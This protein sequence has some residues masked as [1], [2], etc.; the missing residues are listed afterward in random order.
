MANALGTR[1][2]D[3][4]MRIVHSLPR[5]GRELPDRTIA[6]SWIRCANDY[7]LDPARPDAPTIIEARALQDRREQLADLM[8]I[9]AAE[10]D[11]L[12]DQISGSGYALLLTDSD[13]IILY[14]KVDPTLKDMFRGAGL[15]PGADWSERS[16]GTNGMGTCIAERKPVTVHRNDHFY[17]H[18]IGLTCFGV[19]IRGPVD[20]VIAVL[21]ASCIGSHDTRATQMHTMALVRL[22][23]HIIEKCLFLRH[24]E[25]NAVLRFHSR[26]DLVN[27]FHDG[28]LA[29]AE[30]G[31]VIGA[32]HTAAE[33]LEAKDRYE[34][35]G[36]PISEIFDVDGAR[37]ASLE[38]LRSAS[39]SPL[40]DPRRGQGY[41]ANLYAGAKYGQSMSTSIGHGAKSSTR[42][43]PE[44]VKLPAKPS[45]PVLT[46]EDLAGEDPQ[47]LRN[48]RSAHR[49]VDSG[50]SVLI[51]GPTG[52]GKE[53]FAHAMH[54]ASRR[55]A[56]PFV[57]VNC[58]AI[59]ETLIESELFGYKPGAFTGARKEGMKGK[60][61]QSSGGTLFLDE[62][63]DMP[64]SLQTRL[65]RVLEEQ[66]IVPLGSEVPIKVELHVI[67]A[68]HRNLR[69]MIARGEFRE[70]LYYRLNGITLELPRLADRS[71]RERVIHRALAAET[72]NGR[73]AAIEVDALQRLVSYP[74][75]GNI[76]ELRNVIRTALAICDGGVVRVLDLPREIR[77]PQPVNVGAAALAPA[78]SAAAAPAES[79][80]LETCANPLQAAERAALLRVIEKCRGN[81][82]HAAEHLGV[83]RNTLYRKMKTH[84]IPTR[85]G[86]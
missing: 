76:R 35:V 30:D 63:G 46:L 26:P 39:L 64:L 25:H 85:S 5:P 8:Q 16:R 7:R 10:V 56:L 37:G 32:D 74:W 82:T 59:P 42:S 51:Q 61:L 47:M 78:A 6:R 33:L 58:A 14:E 36:R 17:T 2:S 40:R 3:D 24:H 55:A 18:H 12:Y 49:I 31:T 68:S 1:H 44:V 60:I 73:P 84:G 80:P 22:S 29:L 19:P 75:P 9:G 86:S 72:H 41:Y 38:L 83:S 27:L 57:A 67:A 50:V 69:E 62:I 20:D 53:A 81:M 43:N 71:D 66:E 15:V 13:G 45:P 79:E 77:E 23:A 34:L 21:D 70:D 65:L 28:A 11:R 48:V 54:H 4:V 52:S